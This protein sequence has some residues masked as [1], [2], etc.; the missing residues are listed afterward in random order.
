MQSN[1]SLCHG[2]FGNAELL[3]Q[4][5]DEF[6]DDGYLKPVMELAEGA[7]EKYLVGRNPWPCGVLNGGEAP[8]L[9]L[10][11]AGIGYFYL[12]LYDRKKVPSVLIVGPA[13]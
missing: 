12:R 3:I 8:N 9:M 5:S 2:N 7:R 4:A 11:L 1:F 10:G 6:A 13:V